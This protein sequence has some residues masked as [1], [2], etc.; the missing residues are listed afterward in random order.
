MTNC[1]YKYKNIIKLEK[2]KIIV[3][4]KGQSKIKIYSIVR[5]I[6]R[7]ILCNRHDGSPM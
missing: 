4:D 5:K 2:N 7:A 3:V 1:K 6:S